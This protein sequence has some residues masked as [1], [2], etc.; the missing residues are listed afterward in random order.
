MATQAWE[1]NRYRFDPRKY[2]FIERYAAHGQAKRAALECGW[3]E[4]YAQS[5]SARLLRDPEVKDALNEIRKNAMVKAEYTVETAM[6]EAN[7]AIEFAKETENANAYVKAVELRSKLSGL[8]VDKIDLRQAI[9]FSIQI[10][11]V[12]APALPPA[13]V[14]V[15]PSG[16][17]IP[18]AELVNGSTDEEASGESGEG[19]DGNDDPWS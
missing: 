8:L 9:G 11:G 7:A 1:K 17:P 10:I 15:L 14:K 3:S 5:A 6:A 18:E 13:D 4:E 16:E 2:K 19:N 12:G